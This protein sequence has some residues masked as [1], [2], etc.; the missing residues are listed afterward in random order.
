LLSNDSSSIIIEQVKISCRD[1][2]SLA[3][4]YFYFDFNDEMAQSV[5]NLI[6]SLIMQFSHQGKH[7]EA[8]LKDLYTTHGRGMRPAA[9][10]SLNE[11]LQCILES[12]DEAYVIIDALDECTELDTLLSWIEGVLDWKVSKLHLLATS[13]LEQVIQD[14]LGPSGIQL[15]SANPDIEIFIRDTLKKDR[16]LKSWPTQMKEKINHALMNGASGM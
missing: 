11:A 9:R 5:D 16:K 6:R 15:T 10:E 1:N 14:C 8:I 4:A 7:A 13:R 3:L 12:F 2:P